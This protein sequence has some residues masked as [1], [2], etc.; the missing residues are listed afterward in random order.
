MRSV[1]TLVH[2]CTCC[3]ACLLRER[4]REWVRVPIVTETNLF[5]AFQLRNERTRL[6]VS[7]REYKNGIEKKKKKKNLLRFVLP[8]IN[9]SFFFRSKRKVET[10][11]AKKR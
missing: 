10:R 9:T 6:E 2:R 11:R 7:R 3:T 1:P 4:E 5:A 8:S